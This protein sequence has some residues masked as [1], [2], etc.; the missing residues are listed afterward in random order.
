MYKDIYIYVCVCV[1]IYIY[2][3]YIGG[4]CIY[5]LYICISVPFY[6]KGTEILKDSLIKMFSKNINNRCNIESK[7]L[8]YLSISVR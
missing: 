1:F 6:T 4:V 8:E 7:A 2:R 3:V 5:M